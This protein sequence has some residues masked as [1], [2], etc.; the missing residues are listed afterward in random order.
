MILNLRIDTDTLSPEE[1]AA[2]LRLPVL[3]EDELRHFA[4]PYTQAYSGSIAQNKNAPP[5]VLDKLRWSFDQHTR[6]YVAT[7]PNTSKETLE[8]LSGDGWEG[9][10]ER[11][12]R[13]PNTP[14]ATLVRM[15]FDAKE[16]ARQRSIL[17]NPSLTLEGLSEISKGEMLPKIRAIVDREIER[18]GV[19]GLLTE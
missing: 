13:H 4:D 10:R 2:V 18:R 11:V 9:V 14:E 17:D 6:M 1:M 5:D 19:L 8:Y 7:H 15:F 3:T 12:A 16:L